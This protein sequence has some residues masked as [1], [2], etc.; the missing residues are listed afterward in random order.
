MLP[1]LR[2]DQVFFA[3]GN[4]EKSIGINDSDISCMKPPVGERFFCLLGHVI[5]AFYDVRTPHEDLTVFSNSDLLIS[6]RSTNCVQAQHAGSVECDDWRCF[7]Q[8]ISFINW[9]PNGPKKFGD[10]IF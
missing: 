2:D 4:F 10:L 1:A 7:R 6:D 5:V 9:E 3:I 8:S